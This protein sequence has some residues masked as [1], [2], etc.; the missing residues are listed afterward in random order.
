MST[1]IAL[2]K[3]NNNDDRA[4]LTSWVV[5]PGN[6]VSKGQVIA[7]VETTKTSIEVEAPISGWLY[8]TILVGEFVNFGGLI[9]RIF[10][11]PTAFP[12]EEAQK[13]SSGTHKISKKAQALIEIHNVPLEAII[14][15]GEI[16]F[17]KDVLAY[18][19]K[20]NLISSQPSILATSGAVQ[21]EVGGIREALTFLRN[22]MKS[23]FN[24]HVPTGTLLNDRFLLAEKWGFGTGASI[25]D[26][27]L[28]LGEV[29]VGENCWI[30][31]NTILDGSGGGLEIGDWTSIGSGSHVYTHHTIER[32]LTGGLAP[33]FR[34]PTS[35]GKC[36]FIAP[37]S[38]I[39]PNT[40]IGAYC[41][42]TS[43]SYV[44]GVFPDYSIIS[45]NPAKIVGNIL[46]NGSKVTKN[47]FGK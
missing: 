32:S 10:D 36:C 3:I 7:V 27:C 13:K 33:F 21:E 17:E 42:V 14:S 38:I 26:E 41:F 31:P 39:G 20:H 44:E 37:K 29:T 15:N 28:I 35:I 9:G 12:L 45:G 4:R 24:R 19:N 16:V 43:F 23:K 22:E 6:Q 30:G 5:N 46:I 47:F 2:P 34:A 8:S 40:V 1:N 11:D 25:Y 18:L